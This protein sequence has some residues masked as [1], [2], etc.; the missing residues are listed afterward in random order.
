ML[1]QGKR[2]LMVP[3]SAFLQQPF[4]ILEDAAVGVPSEQQQ[5][6]GGQAGSGP[7]GYPP[8]SPEEHYVWQQYMAGGPVHQEL[9]QEAAPAA[10]P[11]GGVVQR[12]SW[13]CSRP[14][15]SSLS[16]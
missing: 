10:A 14:R 4:M 11:A 13:R 16:A 9:E 7:P 15:S 5:Q 12:P 3:N 8:L 2:R 1:R 6:A